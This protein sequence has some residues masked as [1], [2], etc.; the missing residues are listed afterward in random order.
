MKMIHV[1][2]YCLILFLASFIGQCFV[3]AAPQ[4]NW[5]KSD[6]WG[7]VSGAE[8]MIV[9]DDGLIWIAGNNKIAVHE[10]NGTLVKEFTSGLTGCNDLALDSNGNIYARIPGNLIKLD[11]NGSQVWTVPLS[12]I[13]SIAINKSDQI[14]ATVRDFAVKIFNLDGNVTQTISNTSLNQDVFHNWRGQDL[15]RFFS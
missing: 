5:Y 14:Y 2:N 1:K 8:N 15:I 7:G 3:T 4:D 9:T 12:E 10:Q 13:Q 6:S 11:A